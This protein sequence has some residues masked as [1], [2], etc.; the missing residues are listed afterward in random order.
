[1]STPITVSEQLLCALKPLIGRL[2][3]LAAT[4][5]VVR[6][7]LRHLGESLLALAAEPSA[8]LAAPAAQADRAGVT[9]ATEEPSAEAL[10]TASESPLAAA[11]QT[12]SAGATAA[13]LNGAASR[14]SAT[15]K[16][17]ATLRTTQ[18]AVLVYNTEGFRQ[19]SI[20]T[21]LDLA[22]LAQR[23]VVKK[24]AAMWAAQRQ[25]CA[26]QGIRSDPDLDH[27][28]MKL[29]EYAQALPDCYLWMCQREGPPTVDAAAFEEL[30]GCFE[31]TMAIVLLLNDIINDE[32]E[33][34][35]FLEPALTLAGE[36]QAM[37]RNAVSAVNGTVDSDQ[38]KLF[39]WLKATTNYY[40]IYIRDFMSK[41]T[42]VKPETWIDLKTRIA[43]LATRIEEVKQTVKQREKLFSKVRHRRRVIQAASGQELL[44]DW[45]RLVEAV[46]GLIESG[47]P[48]SNTELREQLLPVLD[49][50]P[51][52]LEVPKNFQLVLREI[53][54][55][56]AK[57]AP[58]TETVEAITPIA[59]VLQVRSLLRDQTV[60]LIGGERRQAAANA[61]CSAFE[62]RELIWIEGH[63][64]TYT[65]FEP[66][67]ARPEVSVVLLAIRWSRHGF[68]EVKEFCDRY[69]KPFVRLLGGYNP[70]QVAHTILNQIGQRL[71]QPEN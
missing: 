69:D 34:E 17:Y 29:I 43:E 13:R 5:P 60:V 8:T 42:A 55:F 44:E 19:P 23:C 71:L 65:D 35:D 9:T 33:G 10:I 14:S 3:A 66:H 6:H 56:L 27:Q 48:P 32:D 22:V 31:A 58:A 61:L 11:E 20:M 46:N 36:A 24:E 64:Q 68:G 50:M 28:R 67:V 18:E 21:T 15:G 47:L 54:R 41:W 26:E 59:E 45:Q 49:Q 38:V 70:N 37:L 57:R 25:R 12:D 30:A 1:M 39:Q 16:S 63:D 2:Q 52:G 40:R 53:D 62:L 7:E 4:D 51:G